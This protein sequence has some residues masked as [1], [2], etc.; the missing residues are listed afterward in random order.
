MP[1]SWGAG[2][3]VLFSVKNS[4]PLVLGPDLSLPLDFV[5]RTIAILGIRG[6]GKTNTGSVVIEELLDRN[7][8]AV[9]IDPTDAWWGIRSQYPVFIFGGSHGDVPLAETDGK[10]VAQFVV[11]EHVPAILSLRHLRKGAQRRFVTDFCEEIYHLKGKDENRTALCI[12][13][14][15]A[16]LFVPQKVMGENART[17]GAVE[18]LIARGR[19][20]GFGVVLISQRAA[21][22]NKDV[23]TQADAI[24]THRLTSPQDRKALGEWFEANASTEKQKEI[25]GS[26]ASLD[27]GR[28]WVW[29]PT[30]EVMKCVLIRKRRTFDSSATPKVGE[31]IAAPKKLTE[32]NLD[33]LKAKMGAALQQAKDN[34]PAELKKQIAAMKLALAKT[35]VTVMPAKPVEVRVE[36]PM[37]TDA[38]IARLENIDRQLTVIGAGTSST[39]DMLENLLKGIAGRLKELRAPVAPSKIVRVPSR[40]AILRP[41]PQRVADHNGTL[42]KAQTRVLT[43]LAQNESGCEKNK[44]ALLSGYSYSGGFRNILSSLRTSGY[45]EG[46]ND[47]QM[48]ITDAGLTAL[49]SFEPLPFGTALAEYWLANPRFGTPEQKVLRVLLDNRHGIDAQALAQQSGYEYSGGFRNILS[50]LRT[51][52]V[53]VGRNT[54]TLK[55]SDELFD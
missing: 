51:A 13:I 33:A 12:I 27:N 22:I 32:I 18:D 6:A 55:A 26:L 2:G 7:L 9:V 24:I 11:S 3:V 34:D 14:D 48:R 25:L 19:S 5:S 46:G 20:S 30:L 8:P 40:A 1:A 42:D 53:L 39:Q 28:A 43:V 41:A 37:F 17:V 23:L 4:L 38:E 31:V 21:T 54:E 47:Q 50:T 10:V 29:A 52:G 15:E 49:G 36:V 45:M 16:P 35:P 44:L